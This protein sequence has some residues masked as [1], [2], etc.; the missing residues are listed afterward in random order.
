MS[1]IAF[2]SCFFLCFSLPLWSSSLLH[3]GT[4]PHL[5]CPHKTVLGALFD[6]GIF[7]VMGHFCWEHYAKVRALHKGVWS[8]K[9]KNSSRLSFS[10]LL[11]LS[12][13]LG[14]MSSVFL[15]LRCENL[16]KLALPEFG[17]WAMGYGLW[18]V[19]ADMACMIHGS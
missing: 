10:V 18:L 9:G 14:Y 13:S 5:P 19:P 12:V 4:G 15:I 6:P 17:L 8:I 1:V 16:L 2:P 7:T 3:D 11:F